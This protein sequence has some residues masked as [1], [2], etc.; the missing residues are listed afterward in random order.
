RSRATA[1]ALA[2]GFLLF[3]VTLVGAPFLA[4]ILV[5]GGDDARRETLV[6]LLRLASP[7]EIT[8]PL[9]YVA[10]SSANARERY[11]LAAGSFIL[12]PLPVIALLVT[13]AAT[14]QLVAL[15]YVAGTVLQL[16]LLW[17][18]EPESRPVLAGARRAGPAMS[19]RE[20]VLPVGVAFGILAL[21]PLE[22]RGL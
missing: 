12:P 17:A 13:G 20:D 10:M 6:G 22:V 19:V 3:V 14:V 11:L 7:L 15:A 16:A 1:I 21:L 2:V 8:W 9:I 4:G 5:P 18:V